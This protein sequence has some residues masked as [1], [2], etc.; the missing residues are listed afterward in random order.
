MARIRGDDRQ[1]R[2]LAPPIALLLGLASP[3]AAQQE[4]ITPPPPAWQFRDGDRWQSWSQDS[5]GRTTNSLRVF[6]KRNGA[7]VALQGIDDRA[8]GRD[9]RSFQQLK[10][11][12]FY[13]VAP[14][15]NK[16]FATVD[17]QLH[18]FVN[19]Q[20]V[21]L[22]IGTILTDKR[23]T[24]YEV[25]VRTSAYEADQLSQLFQH[26]AQT[27]RPLGENRTSPILLPTPDKLA[28]ARGAAAAGATAAVPEEQSAAAETPAAGGMSLKMA[29]LYLLLGA[30]IA[31]VLVKLLGRKRVHP[32]G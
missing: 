23:G 28:A 25:D 8:G 27:E 17:G 1:P 29:A 11:P 7:W 6:E 16:F 13:P 9:S 14:Y 18:R 26:S 20:W 21:D 15:D 32:T 24:R 31:V 4:T 12:V 10:S 22:P 19:H 30:G 2:R 3:A 5:F